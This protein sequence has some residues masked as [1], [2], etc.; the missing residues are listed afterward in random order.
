M[1]VLGNNQLNRANSDCGYS[2]IEMDAIA[3]KEEE[4]LEG[5]GCEGRIIKEHRGAF[6]EAYFK[7]ISGGASLQKARESAVAAASIE[8]AKYN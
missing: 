2:G 1:E 8:A 5:L 7:A 4:R 3:K 6:D